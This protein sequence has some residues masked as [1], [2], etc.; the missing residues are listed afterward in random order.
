MIRRD[1]ATLTLLTLGVAL[2]AVALLAPRPV[3]L[4][5]IGWT[6]LP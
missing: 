2:I 6:L 3:K 4:G 1:P 5:V